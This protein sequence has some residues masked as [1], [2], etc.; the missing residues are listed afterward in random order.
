MTGARRRLVVLASGSG[1]N[2]QAILDACAA[3]RI[4]GDVVAVLSDRGEAYALE[5]ADAAAIPAVWMDPKRAE[6]RRAYDIGLAESVRGYAPDWIVLAGWMRILSSGFLAQFPGQVINLHPAR[7][8]ELAGLHAISRAF[9]EGLA[10]LRTSTG[11]MVHLVPDERV[12]EGPVVATAEVPIVA[13]D[14]LDTLTARMHATEHRLLVD[15]L[16]DLLA[17]TAG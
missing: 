11:V 9:D 6:D 12:D 15:A 4:H 10:G 5:R 2:L 7:P 14:T 1:S 16:R 3:D 13:G 17:G 8:G